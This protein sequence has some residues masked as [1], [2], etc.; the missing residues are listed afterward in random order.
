[1]NSFNKLFY[2]TSIIGTIALTPGITLA[3]NTLTVYTLSTDGP[4]A[5][6]PASFGPAT[7]AFSPDAVTVNPDEYVKINPGGT[8]VQNSKLYSGGSLTNP[9][10]GNPV[11]YVTL[12][13]NTLLDPSGNDAQCSATFIFNNGDRIDTSGYYTEVAQTRETGCITTNTVQLL[14]VLGGT[15]G[16]RGQLK[17]THAPNAAGY[18]DSTSC[19]H[20]VHNFQFNFSLIPHQ[21]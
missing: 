3:A 5:G 11:G 7:D 2:V 14:V 20:T 9:V 19:N 1:M 6:A 16:V 12:T 4:D 8:F 17:I 13:C 15:K 21:E 18:V 10:N